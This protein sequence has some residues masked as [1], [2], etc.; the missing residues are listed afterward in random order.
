MRARKTR[1]FAPVK[2]KREIRDE[3]RRKSVLKEKREELKRSGKLP[4]K[5]YGK[6]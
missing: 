6:Y 4:I 3:A 2:N 5:K 1:F